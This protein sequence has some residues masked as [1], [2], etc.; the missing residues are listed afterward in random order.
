MALD[1][2]HAAQDATKPLISKL[3]AVPALRERYLGHVRAIAEKS[4]DWRT[5]GPLAE[6]LHTLI[7]EDV[8]A[9]TRK[10]DSTE[11]F[12]KSLTQDVAG[13]GF[14]PFGGGSMGLK[15]FADQRRAYLLGYRP[16]ATGAAP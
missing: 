9:D 2:L 13:S 14:G 1:P 3:L 16:K 4:L 10:L 8:R 12:E 7:A 15:N 6:R 11:A 5:L